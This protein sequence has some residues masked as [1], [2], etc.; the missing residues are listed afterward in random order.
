[1]SAQPDAISGRVF[2]NLTQFKQ[3]F[4]HLL[5]NLQTSYVYFR[6]IH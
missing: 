1:M 2:S 6:N 5:A 3:H 4:A